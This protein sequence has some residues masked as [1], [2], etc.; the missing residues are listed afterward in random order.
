MKLN[1][2]LV[3]LEGLK[4]KGD[5]ERE[6][7]GLEKNSKEIKKGF[8]FVA[9]KGFSVDGHEYI[10]DAI[11]NGAVAVMLEEGCDL[12]SLNIPEDVTIVM[13]KDTRQGLA[14]CSS[15]FYGN[16]SKK[17]KLIGITGTKGKTTTTFMIKEILEKRKIARESKDFVESDRLRD[18]LKEKGYVVKDQKDGQKI[19]KV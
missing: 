2:M 17:L 11:E 18:I 6:I 8:L 4:V 14:I 13:A 15:N 7:I 5:L 1:E 19:E 12:K 16:P 10:A 3:G 9:I